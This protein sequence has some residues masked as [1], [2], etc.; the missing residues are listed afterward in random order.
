DDFDAFLENLQDNLGDILRVDTLK[1][2]METPD[3]NRV[4]VLGG[5][6]TMVPPG[7]VARARSAGR[8]G[9][10]AGGAILRRAAEITAPLHGRPVASEAL[11]PLDLGS[12]RMPAL[13]LFGSVDPHRFSPA[14]GT[15]L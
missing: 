13:L 6:L 8:R 9:Q 11:I 10:V 4:P 12:G 15:D 7:T 2:V 3:S 5:P 1:L 14:H